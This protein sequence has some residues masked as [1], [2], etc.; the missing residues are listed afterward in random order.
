MVTM[1]LQSEQRMLDQRCWNLLNC[2]SLA[3]KTYYLL[4][5]EVCLDWMIKVYEDGC[6]MLHGV[7]SESGTVMKVADQITKVQHTCYGKVWDVLATPEPTNLADG[8]GALPLHSDLLFYESA[9]GIQLLHGLR[10]DECVVG[11]ESVLCHV[12][13]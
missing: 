9:P 10:K 11:D 6:S 4:K 7:P 3:T 5:I 2:L 8:E 1:S 12:C 13:C